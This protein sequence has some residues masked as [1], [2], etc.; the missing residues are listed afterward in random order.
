MSL[1]IKLIFPL[2]ETLMSHYRST[3]LCRSRGV[4]AP[5]HIDT[6]GEPINT[7]PI[8][9]YLTTLSFEL[10]ILRVVLFLSVFLERIPR[11]RPSFKH[12][13]PPPAH[14]YRITRSA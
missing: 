8:N 4:L 6:K 3:L 13:S 14:G 7:A 5:P 1:A 10:Q 9:L 2:A 12:L 11:P